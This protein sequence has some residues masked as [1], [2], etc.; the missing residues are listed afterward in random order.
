MKGGDCKDEYIS[1]MAQLRQN[2][3]VTSAVSNY[4]NYF[5]FLMYKH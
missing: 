5:S 1:D 4:P 2:D 3:L